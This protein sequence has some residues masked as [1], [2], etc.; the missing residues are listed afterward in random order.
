M[1]FPQIINNVFLRLFYPVF[2][3]FLG[4]LNQVCPTKGRKNRA[5]NPSKIHCLE[6]AGQF[7]KRK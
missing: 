7:M 3:P 1:N 4:L 2:T 5:K 6:F